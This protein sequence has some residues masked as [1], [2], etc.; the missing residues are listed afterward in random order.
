MDEI[1][2]NN[3]RDFK[4]AIIKYRWKESVVILLQREDSGYY[5]TLQL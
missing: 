2:I 5:I 3:T 1:T 4:K